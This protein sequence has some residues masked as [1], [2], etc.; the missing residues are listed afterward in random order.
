M[1]SALPQAGSDPP[2][3]RESPA[4]RILYVAQNLRDLG[5]RDVTVATAAAERL[6]ELAPTV[7]ELTVLLGD[8][9]AF[10]RSGSASWLP[11]HVGELPTDTIN[12]LRAA[13]YDPNPH[14]IQAA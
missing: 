13:I 3:E 9:D 1:T 14:V 8:R 12:A 11:N 6:N 5:S 7:G 10:I 4:R 2:R